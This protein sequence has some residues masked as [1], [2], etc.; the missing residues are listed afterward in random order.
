MRRA[1]GWGVTMGRSTLQ[2]QRQNVG[3]TRRAVPLLRLR[4]GGAGHRGAASDQEMAYPASTMYTHSHTSRKRERHH[5]NIISLA[6]TRPGRAHRSSHK[7]RPHA[8]NANTHF[9]KIVSLHSFF[10]STSHKQRQA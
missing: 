6:S 2:R 8:G 9:T 7:T 1:R 10:V 3:T 5:G 4:P